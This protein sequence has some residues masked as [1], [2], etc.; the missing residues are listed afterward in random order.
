MTE[1]G[2]GA[3]G[4]AAAHGRRSKPPR[5]ANDSPLGG[6]ARGGAIRSQGEGR[7]A[8]RR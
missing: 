2:H 5:V 6:H 8:R 7:M 1:P 3:Y 4:F